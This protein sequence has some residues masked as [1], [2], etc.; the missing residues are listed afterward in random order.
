[1]T[2]I[3]ILDT[4]EVIEN[5]ITIEQSIGDVASI[6]N[7][8]NIHPMFGPF[9]CPDCELLGEGNHCGKHYEFHRF[10]SP[11]RNIIVETTEGCR[12]LPY[13]TKYEVQR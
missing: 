3:R 2:D 8:C 5:V 6:K 9:Q 11:P 1:M 13:D 12:E 7:I 10:L 4:G